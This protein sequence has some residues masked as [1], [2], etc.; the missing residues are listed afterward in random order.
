MSTNLSVTQNLKIDLTFDNNQTKSREISQG[1]LIRVEY[2]DHGIRKTV[3]GEVV[4]IGT[5]ASQNTC[6]WYLI[7]DGSVD[8]E[9]HRVRINPNNILDLDIIQKKNQMFAVSSP[10]DST[11]ID[12]VRIYDG[13]FQISIDGGYSWVTPNVNNQIQEEE[14]STGDDNVT[15]PGPS[16][17][18]K[19]C[20]LV[21]SMQKEIQSLTGMVENLQKQVNSYHNG[22]TET[23]PDGEFAEDEIFDE[24]Y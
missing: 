7:V 1:D 20:R 17:V 13:V 18:D 19:L 12:Q 16:P 22:E 2:N 8:F 23:S 5:N 9:G 10:K 3:E 24:V 15:P 11:H 4:K 6:A 14:G 21:R